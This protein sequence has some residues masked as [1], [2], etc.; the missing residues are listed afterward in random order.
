MQAAVNARL[1][2]GTGAVS[3]NDTI[4]VGDTVVV[5]NPVIYGSNST[6]AV[7][8]D[9]YTVMEV[10]GDRAVIGVDGVVTSAIATYNLRK[11]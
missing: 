4:S 3:Y 1:G 7:N 5:T 11:V 10:V 9:Y 2:A 6:F 8:Y